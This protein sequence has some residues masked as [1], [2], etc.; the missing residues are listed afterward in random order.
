MP[1]VVAIEPS[2]I[3]FAPDMVAEMI[4]VPG[5]ATNEVHATPANAGLA[6]ITMAI[7][8]Q[9]DKRPHARIHFS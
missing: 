8:I 7:A 1:E 3:Q 9:A 6:T 4:T 2:T 5:G